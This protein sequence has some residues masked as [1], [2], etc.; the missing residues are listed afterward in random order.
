MYVMDD[1]MEY[2]MQL[3]RPNGALLETATNIV[4]AVLRFVQIALLCG[5]EKWEKIRV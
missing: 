5:H 4:T 3:L 1:G 2:D